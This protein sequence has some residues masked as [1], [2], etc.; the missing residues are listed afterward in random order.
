[1][2]WEDGGEVTLEGG[3]AEPLHCLISAHGFNLEELLSWGEISQ[4]RGAV[5]EVE[6]TEEIIK[7]CLGKPKM[8]WF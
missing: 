7:I 3:V 1:M 8:Q 2:Q 6:V 5:G 4:F